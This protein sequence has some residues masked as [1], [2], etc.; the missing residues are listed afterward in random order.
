[1]QTTTSKTREPATEQ[2][3]IHL[4]GRASPRVQRLDLYAAIHKALRMMMTDALVRVGSTDAGSATD[5]RETLAIVRDLL[6]ACERHIAKENKWVHPALE[7]ARPGASAQIAS[8]HGEHADCIEELAE[9]VL[10]IET[11]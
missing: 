10:E 3:G 11:G 1:M 2:T 7:R 8:E 4:A 9:L 6:T 5:V